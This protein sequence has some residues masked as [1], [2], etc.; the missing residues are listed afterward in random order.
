MNLQSYI[1][2]KKAAVEKALEQFLPPATTYPPMIHEAIRYSVFAGG[3]RLRPLLV[4]A[5]A[6]ILGKQM[7]AVMPTACALELIHTFSLIHDD[8]PSIDNGDYR[9]GKPTC[10]RVYGEAIAML[11]GDALLNY[12]FELMVR[13]REYPGIKPEAVL[14]VIE[15]V[16]KAIG[17]QGMLGGEVMDILSEGKTG[18]KELVE[19]IH[20][21]KTA[22][23][24]SVSLRAGAILADGGAQEIQ[25]LSDYGQYLGLAFQIRDDILNV[26]GDEKKL[27]KPVGTDAGRKKITYP[28]IFG[29]EYA[30]I[31]VQ[32]LSQQA[33]QCLKIF[34][35]RG[36]ILSQLADYLAGREV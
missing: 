7:S 22:T 34:G 13:N 15:E 16:S 17:T 33:K 14:L 8:L 10:H 21:Y 20:S 24:I 6:E 25:G 23:F 19:Y 32:E 3:K 12:A 9:R 2:E 26:E 29:L 5:A 31:K 1:E 28:A 30:R 35:P 4:I 27:G 36:E 11:A 18:D